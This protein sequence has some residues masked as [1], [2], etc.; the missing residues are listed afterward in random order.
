MAENDSGQH[1]DVAILGAGPAGCSAAFEL[2]EDFKVLLLDRGD[3]PQEKP[4]GGLLC[5]ESIE[6]LRKWNMPREILASPSRLNLG[7]IDVDNDISVK[8][9]RKFWNV[10]RKRLSSWLIERL[11]SSVK[12]LNKT[13]VTDI[14][15]SESGIHILTNNQHSPIRCN[16][17]IG[18]DGYFSFVRR[19]IS[20][21]KP[22]QVVG[23]QALLITEDNFDESMYFIFDSSISPIYSW[24]IPK[25][26]GILMGTTDNG[27][28]DKL[29]MFIQKASTLFKINGP[30]M[31]K[32]GAP[33]FWLQDVNKDIIFGSGNVLLAGEAAGFV[34]PSSFE[35]ISYALQSG[36][37]AGRAIKENRGNV[38]GSYREACR[39]LVRRISGQ[40]EKSSIMFDREKRRKYLGGLKD[41]K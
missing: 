38:L 37:L 31:K 24:M 32:T 1:F 3:L 14:R 4:C 27:A 18:S 30:T 7:Y 26:N 11:P 5:E 21:Y 8:T 25:E 35:G 33:V 20:N 40:V 19:K 23:K 17:L 9:G 13:T 39:P 12:I 28:G 10:D 6:V 41:G 29:G 22:K 36:A 34:S 16:F 15:N 2:G